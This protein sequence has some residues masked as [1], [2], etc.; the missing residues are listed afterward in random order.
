MAA[1]D[2]GVVGHLLAHERAALEAHGLVL[3]LLRLLRHISIPLGIIVVADL[4]DVRVQVEGQ[5]IHD[6]VILHLPADVLIGDIR[7]ARCGADDL[8]ELH[9]VH[10]AVE[11]VEHHKLTALELIV[12]ELAHVGVVGN[13]R[14]RVGEHKLLIHHP[15]L[16][17]RAVQRVQQPHAVIF[18][19]DARGLR[20]I[21]EAFKR[22][23]VQ[24]LLR[25]YHA[26]KNVLVGEL[27]GRVFLLALLAHQQQRPFAVAEAPVLK[28]LLN[29]LRLAALQK[30]R[31]K[32]YGHIFSVTQPQT[33]PSAPAH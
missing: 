12:D 2:E 21:K 31:E 27:V 29:E 28:R 14:A 24:L 32:I 18:D 20:L 23:G 30:A 6:V 13:E 15:A 17:H 8:V 1:D 4:D 26:D 10:G 25:V 3:V 33:A 16:R 19:H 11:P 22:L 5:G 7:P 9:L